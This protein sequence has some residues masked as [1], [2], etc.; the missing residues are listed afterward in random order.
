MRAFLLSLLAL[1]A[2]APTEAFAQARTESS[3]AR[4]GVPVRAIRSPGGIEAWLVSDSTV[5][6][7]VLRA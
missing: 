5:P 2:F 6:M 7:V 3:A 1:L 4:H